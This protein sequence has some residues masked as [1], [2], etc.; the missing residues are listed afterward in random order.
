MTKLVDTYE[1][2]DII[3]SKQKLLDL[4]DELKGKQFKPVD[5]LKGKPEYYWTHEI[6]ENIK[7]KVLQQEMKASA[8]GL[9]GMPTSVKF[10]CSV[11]KIH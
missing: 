9:P 4:L 1:H 5:P 10:L 11:L 2:G 7:V 8:W 6:S 3:V